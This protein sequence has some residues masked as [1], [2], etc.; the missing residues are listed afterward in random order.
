MRTH[1][2]RATPSRLDHINLWL[3]VQVR[4]TQKQAQQNHDSRQCRTRSSWGDYRS[5]AIVLGSCTSENFWWQ[6]A[7][8]MSATNFSFV[9][10]RLLVAKSTYS[11]ISRNRFDKDSRSVSRLSMISQSEYRRSFSCRATPSKLDHISLKKWWRVRER[12]TCIRTSLFCPT[13]IS[14]QFT[15]LQGRCHDA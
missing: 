5:N 10:P 6:C 14:I 2:Y 1:I 12:R 8:G 13:W 7:S 4:S 15:S 9:F 11:I 3:V